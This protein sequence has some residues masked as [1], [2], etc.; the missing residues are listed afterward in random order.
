M[1]DK[2]PPTRKRPSR[3]EMAVDALLDDLEELGFNDEDGDP[4]NDD[5]YDTVAVHN[6]LLKAALA[7][8]KEKP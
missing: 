8:S 6:G 2:Q 3:L 5:V 7:A 1:I 4:S